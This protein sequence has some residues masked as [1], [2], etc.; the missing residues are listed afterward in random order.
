MAKLGPLNRKTSAIALAV[1]ASI[2]A[3]VSTMFVPTSILEAITGATGLSELIPATAAPLGDTARA[4]IA[5][6][7]GAVM[8]ILAAA[9]LLRRADN[10]APATAKSKEA[11]KATPKPIEKKGENKMIAILKERMGNMQMPKMPWARDKDSDD[12]FEL[13]DLPKIRAQDAHPDSPA[14]KPISAVNDLADVV[15]DVK[16]PLPSVAQADAEWQQPM[17]AETAQTNAAPRADMDIAEP[18]I[19]EPIAGQTSPVPPSYIPPVENMDD[20]ARD[21]LF[22]LVAQ[23][24]KAINGRKASLAKLEAAAAQIAQEKQRVSEPVATPQAPVPPAPQEANVKAEQ[25][26]VAEKAAAQKA[27]PRPPLEAVPSQKPESD[28]DEM[29]AALNAALA[30]LQRMNSK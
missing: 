10:D 25:P 4:L 15:L 20:D 30:T 13:S 7:A 2:I 17:A 12:V 6:G 22:E 28:D 21:N 3:S 27:M 29:D 18:V 8:M 24:E 11:I 19:A 26:P 1:G 14:R 5:F 9:F 23:F 16:K